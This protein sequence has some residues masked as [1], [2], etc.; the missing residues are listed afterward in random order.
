MVIAHRAC[1]CRFR[2]RACR[3]VFPLF[4]A[5]V[6][7]L[8]D[9]HAHGHSPLA[10]PAD[11]AH[12]TAAQS[13]AECNH[14]RRQHPHGRVRRVLDD[15]SPAKLTAAMCVQATKRH[16]GQSKPELL[17]QPRRARRAHCASRGASVCDAP[18]VNSQVRH[19]R[20][21]VCSSCSYVARTV[22]WST[23]C[24]SPHGHPRLWIGLKR[25]GESCCYRACASHPRDSTALNGLGPDIKSTFKPQPLPQVAAA[26]VLSVLSA[27]S[28][29]N[30]H[31]R[32]IT[33]FA[34]S[35]AAVYERM[36]ASMVRLGIGIEC[37][38]T[39][40]YRPASISLL[41]TLLSHF[42]SLEMMA[43]RSHHRMRRQ[44]RMAHGSVGS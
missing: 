5:I 31:V 25:I 22:P 20:T 39:D 38:H 4:A 24:S 30:T 37:C 3:R 40:P 26:N 35:L 8:C 6:E 33:V 16:H 18:A 34:E 42:P 7:W 36:E 9:M 15:L 10:V 28:V 27:V 2:R 23:S 17:V 11:R 1:A 43:A 44:S 19:V 29:T 21:P 12:S 32:E 14:R 41:L 13:S